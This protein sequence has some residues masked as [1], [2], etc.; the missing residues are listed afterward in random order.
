MFPLWLFRIVRHT[1]GLDT[2][3]TL[4]VAW[5]LARKTNKMLVERLVAWLGFLNLKS[6]IGLRIGGWYSWLGIC[7]TARSANF[8]FLSINAK[9]KG[10][11]TFMALRTERA[12]LKSAGE[13]S[14]ALYVQHNARGQLRASVRAWSV[15]SVVLNCHWWRHRENSWPRLLPHTIAPFRAR[16]VCVRPLS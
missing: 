9:T 7:A 12:I 6:P 5:L 10:Y 1:A 2:G 14:N 16:V 3:S 8:S 15:W 11:A 13:F 4:P